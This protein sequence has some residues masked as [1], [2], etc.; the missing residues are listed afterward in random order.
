MNETLP[1]GAERA[2][3]ERLADEM[4]VV[5]RRTISR[6]TYARTSSNNEVNVSSALFAYAWELKQMART[7]TASFGI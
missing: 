3:L 5:A 4:E 2:E 1:S 6:D 7:G